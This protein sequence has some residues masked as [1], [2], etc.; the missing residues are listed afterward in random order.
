LADAAVGGGCIALA[1]VDPDSLA[2]AMRSLLKN[3]NELATLS[4]AAR[5]RKLQSWN[6][7]ANAIVSWMQT[8][9]PKT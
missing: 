1:S 9:T 7:Y 3:P 5:S 2:S 8:L 6:G 4:A